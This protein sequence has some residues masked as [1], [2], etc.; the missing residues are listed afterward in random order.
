MPGKKSFLTLKRPQAV[1]QAVTD[2]LRLDPMVDNV[3]RLLQ[4]Y[5]FR[6]VVLPASETGITGVHKLYGQVAADRMFPIAKWFYIQPVAPWE[7][8][9][10]MRHEFGIFL[11]GDDSSMAY[12][13]LLT[14][15]NHLLLSLGITGFATAVTSRGCVNCQK[16]YREA[17]GE[18]LGVV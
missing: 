4:N 15:V 10:P 18:S 9:A 16:N 11:L 2:E 7:E 1:T 17:L 6:Q 13:Q 8:R 14:T 3:S 12:A 5:G